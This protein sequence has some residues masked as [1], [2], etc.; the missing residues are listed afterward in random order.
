VDLQV[1]K[2]VA[3]AKALFDLVAPEGD[4]FPAIVD[5]EIDLDY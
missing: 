2:C 4:F 5:P 3:D 1:E